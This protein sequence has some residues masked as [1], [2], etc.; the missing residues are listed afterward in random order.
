M[1]V[2]LRAGAASTDITP[3]AVGTFLA[4]F[5]MGRTSR[6]VLAPL[7]ATA[8][9]VTD[10]EQE[11]VL[12]SLDLIGLLRPWIQRIRERVTAVAGDRVVVACTH[13][14]SGP[15]TM[16]Y[17]GPSILGLFP[18]SDGKDPAYM[19]ALVES[20]AKAVDEAVH[21]A[22]PVVARPASFSVPPD[23]AR[24]DR[25]GGG[26]FDDAVALALDDERGRR[27]AT[28]VCYA[29]HPETLWEK[30][31]LISPDY[32]GYLRDRVQARAGGEVAFFSGPLGAMLTPNVDPRADVTA[33]REYTQQH[34]H[35]LGDAVEDALD[36]ALADTSGVVEL[37][38][39]PV[40]LPNAN[41]RFR[42]LEGLGLVDVQSRDG[43]VPTAVHRVR[44]GGFTLWTAP[45]EVCPELGAELI[46]TIPA[47]HRA[48]VSLCEDELGYILREDMFDNAEYSYEVTMSLGRTTAGV[49][50][51]AYARWERLADESRRTG[52]PD[53]VDAAADPA[54][55]DAELDAAWGSSTA[56][57]AEGV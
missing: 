13:T 42:L 52:D 31:R 20:V 41:W 47:P 56:A 57:D 39:A 50:R 36:A 48:I 28:V 21:V 49:L 11:V 19:F 6:G 26:R 27:V 14:H 51:A 17:W 18:R 44:I 8:V 22:K 43:A 9:Y 45:G 23:W 7:R 10:G 54:P 34:G 3:R 38:R 32:V 5:A 33:R 30:N 25:K 46:A 16:G 37:H 2:S 24:N 35:R 53:A 12:V 1:S 15:D 29:S 40:T 4:G 55:D